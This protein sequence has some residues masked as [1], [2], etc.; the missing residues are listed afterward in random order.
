MSHL[1]APAIRDSYLST[2]QLSRALSLRDLT[3]PDQGPHAMQTLLNEIVE[4]LHTVWQSTTNLVRASPLVPVAEN[5]DRLGYQADDVTRALRYT[6]YVSST[7][8][9]RSHT[10]AMI[11]TAL[12]RYSRPDSD[13]TTARTLPPTVDELIVS[14]GM[15]YR[16]DAVDRSHV[17]EPHQVD[18]WRVRNS[19]STSHDDL[20][21]MVSTLVEVVLP[22]AQWRVTDAAHPYTTGGL[23]IDIL[24]DGTWLELA[25]CGRIHPDVLHGSGLDPTGWSGLALGLGLERALM[26]RKGI[27]DIRYLRASEPRIAEQ[28]R[29]LHPWKHVSPLP[30]ARRDLS[31]VVAEDEDEETLGDRVRDRL[32]E[33]AEVVESVTVLSRT[34]HDDLPQSARDRLRTR[35]GQANVLVRL[36]LRPLDRTLT[37]DE[38]NAIRNRIYTAIHEGPV[39]EL[40]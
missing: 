39:M 17:G 32:G 12:D 13:E 31:V 2:D 18:L 4:A 23:Q 19:P 15:V 21:T 20:L 7:V 24:H 33:D 11:P 25:E 8:M 27:P 36:I 38:A 29:N 14:P 6:R 35:D 3:D 34:L 9:L 22:G 28:M 1:T 16:R 37:S 40:I 26:L 5:Y 30:P 10:S